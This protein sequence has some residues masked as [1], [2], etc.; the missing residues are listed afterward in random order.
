[1]LADSGDRIGRR[2]HTALAHLNL[3]SNVVRITYLLT[4]LCRVKTIGFCC[5]VHKGEILTRLF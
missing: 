4:G 3:A 1:M 2:T 5:V